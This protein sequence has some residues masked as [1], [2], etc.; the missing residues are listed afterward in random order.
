MIFNSKATKLFPTLNDALEYMED[1]GFDVA[2]ADLLEKAGK[3]VEA[4]EL[5]IM[6]GRTIRAIELLLQDP[7]D[8]RAIPRAIGYIRDGL[9]KCLS[10]GVKPS[11]CRE[12]P[13]SILDHLIRLA[14]EV[15]QS[16]SL[17]QKVRVQVG[18]KLLW[19]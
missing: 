15:M 3:L 19:D 9:W 16:S 17:P 7:D 18:F 4:A 14:E 13:D 6:E 12:A 2:R 11:V 5:H 10:F 8:A 1:Y